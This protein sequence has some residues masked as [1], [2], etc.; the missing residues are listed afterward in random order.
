MDLNIVWV[1]LLWFEKIENGELEL[2]YGIYEVARFV[3]SCFV[4]MCLFK[5]IVIKFWKILMIWE[6]VYNNVI[7]SSR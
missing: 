3:F 1:K 6:N 2:I 7:G 5:R 4:G